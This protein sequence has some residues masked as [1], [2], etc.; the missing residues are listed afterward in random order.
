[1]VSENTESEPYRRTPV[2]VM[3][4][5]GCGKSTVGRA[6]AHDFGAPF[7][8]ADDLHPTSNKEKMRRGEPLTDDDRWPWLD[9]VGERMARLDEAEGPVV[10]ACSALRRAYRERLLAAAP[11]AVFVYLHGSREL[12]A[13]RLAGRSHEFM[14]TTLLDSQLATLEVPGADERAVTVDIAPPPAAVELAAI[15]ALKGFWRTRA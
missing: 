2:V 8:D 7:V 12:L 11:D 13:S 1:M 6:I 9:V 15:R 10:V 5:S 4:V 3:G 14:P